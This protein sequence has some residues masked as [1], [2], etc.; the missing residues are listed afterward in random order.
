MNKLINCLMCVCIIS[1]LSG[2]A[3]ANT[4]YDKTI[5]IS[6]QKELTKRNFDPGP[7]DGL[8][9]SKTVAAIRDFQRSRMH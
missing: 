2:L 3:I 4:S 9:G 6:V 7:I 1:S 5:V 8:L